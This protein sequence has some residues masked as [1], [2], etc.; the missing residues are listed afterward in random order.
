LPRRSTDALSPPRVWFVSP[1]SRYT[2]LVHTPVS[3]TWLDCRPRRSGAPL[4]RLSGPDLL[5]SLVFSGFFTFPFCR[6]ALRLCVLVFLCA[7]SFS[8]LY[9]RYIHRLS[10][11]GA[12]EMLGR[13]P[14]VVIRVLPYGQSRVPGSL[15]QDASWEHLPLP[16]SCALQSATIFL[17]G[18]ASV[19]RRR[20]R[21]W[22]PWTHRRG[23]GPSSRLPGSRARGRSL[24]SFA[25]R[26]FTPKKAT[27][28]PP[29]APLCPRTQ[30][31]TVFDLLTR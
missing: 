5:W 3:T 21:R 28:T 14:Q 11:M 16:S 24:I 6:L 13:T 2:L 1:P 30:S 31:S 29:K 20:S 17:R 15:R 9:Y 7:L 8:V 23:A 19:R 22:L 25:H 10:S 12:P 18:Q 4:A 27:P 26:A